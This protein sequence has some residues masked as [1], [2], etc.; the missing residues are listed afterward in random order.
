MVIDGELAV[1]AYVGIR[2]HCIVILNRFSLAYHVVKDHSVGSTPVQD[3]ASIKWNELHYRMMFH[4][5]I[6]GKDVFVKLT[7]P[8][9]VYGVP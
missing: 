7:F 8:H 9:Y 4:F 2:A 6:G 1:L 3:I 5:G